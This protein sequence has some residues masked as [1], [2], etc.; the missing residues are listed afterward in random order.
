MELEKS[1][2]VKV[3][4][5]LTEYLYPRLPEVKPLISRVLF[6]IASI[7]AGSTYGVKIPGLI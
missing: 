2:L 6:I 1:I 5:P 3:E 7:F 4:I